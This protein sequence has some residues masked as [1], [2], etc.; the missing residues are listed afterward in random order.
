MERTTIPL[1]PTQRAVLQG[2]SDLDPDPA[3]FRRLQVEL[4]LQPMTLNRVLK[5]LELG[6]WVAAQGQARTRERRYRLTDVGRVA[7]AHETPRQ[8]PA[9]RTPFPPSPKRVSPLLMRGVEQ[10]GPDLDD[11]DWAEIVVWMR[12]RARYRRFR[13]ERHPQAGLQVSTPGPGTSRQ[14]LTK[15]TMRAVSNGGVEPRPAQAAGD[16]LTDH[17]ACTTWL[18]TDVLVRQVVPFVAECAATHLKGPDSW[19]GAQEAS[20]PAA[21][22]TSSDPTHRIYRVEVALPPLSRWQARWVAGGAALAALA[23][24]TDPIAAQAVLAMLDPLEKAHPRFIQHDE[25]YP[26]WTACI[27]AVRDAVAA[28]AEEEVPPDLWPGGTFSSDPFCRVSNALGDA[29]QALDQAVDLP[30]REGVRLDAL[31]ALVHAGG[32]DDLRQKPD[33]REAAWHA[34]EQARAMLM[35]WAALARVQHVQW[36]ARHAALRAALGAMLNDLARVDVRAL[37]PEA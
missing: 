28:C 16:I 32:L 8:L 31:V 5:A 26:Y 7:L 6:G 27:R 19:L 12:R 24:I 36:V 3:S 1:S 23:P 13:A 35:T 37:P 29:L 17:L 11:L 34:M 2:L 25:S 20:I 30:A 18:I 4:R 10:Y 33:D 21:A 22:L 9:A 14:A 15:G